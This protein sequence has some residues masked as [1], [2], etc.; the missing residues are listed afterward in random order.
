MGSEVEDVLAAQ[1]ECKAMAGEDCADDLFANELPPHDVALADFWI[2][3]TEVTVAAYRRCV[4]AGVCV[5]QTHAGAQKWWAN[6]QHPV[7]LV[8]WAEA[9]KYCRWV[10]GKLP[11]EA[12]W[13]RAARGW[14]RRIYPWGDIYNPMITNHGRRA[15]HPLDD[16]DGFAELAPVGQFPQGRT[17]E[18]V[19]DLAGN[20]EEWVADWYHPQYDEADAVDPQGPQAGDERVVRGGGFTAAGPWVRGATRTHLLP[21]LRR[22]WLGFRCAYD[23]AR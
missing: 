10:D 16:S 4:A 15:L 18:G 21:S 13:E 6:E 19:D 1:A 9:Q 3:R 23:P 20:V 8:S 5:A 7:V 11:T 22:P 12:Q 14:S 2:D 17:P